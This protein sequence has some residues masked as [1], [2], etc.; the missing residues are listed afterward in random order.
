MAA[1]ELG[2]KLGRRVKIVTG[3]RKGRLELEYY[4]VDD[5]NGLLEELSRLNRRQS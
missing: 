2:D 1:K 3:R 5:L 4:G